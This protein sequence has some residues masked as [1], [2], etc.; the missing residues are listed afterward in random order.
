VTA[1]FL[2][3]I[4]RVIFS[5]LF[6]PSCLDRILRTPFLAIRNPESHTSWIF[7]ASDTIPRN[8]NYRRRK[9]IQVAVRSRRARSR[10]ATV[11]RQF[12]PSGLEAGAAYHRP[13]TQ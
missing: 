9:V 6:C 4:P 8:G 5:I 11:T 12:E 3:E 2:P 13:M 10:D 1:A 7:V